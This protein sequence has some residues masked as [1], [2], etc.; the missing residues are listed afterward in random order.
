MNFEKENMLDIIR[1]PGGFGLI[2]VHNDFQEYY[3]HDE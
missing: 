3:C 2:I 1:P